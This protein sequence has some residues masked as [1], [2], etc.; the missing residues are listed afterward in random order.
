LYGEILGGSTISVKKR[1]AGGS[2]NEKG[3]TQ[4][5]VVPRASQFIEG[6]WEKE[7]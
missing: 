2:L 5:D 7:K 4:G 1:R 3:V 6:G